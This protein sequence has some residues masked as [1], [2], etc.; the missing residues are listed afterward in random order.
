MGCQARWSRGCLRG[1]DTKQ[2]GEAAFLGRCSQSHVST[3]PREEVSDRRGPQCPL[4]FVICEEEGR[5]KAIAFNW[6]TSLVLVSRAL[7]SVLGSVTTYQVP[8]SCSV[9]VVFKVWSRD[10]WSRRS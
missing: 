2:L 6:D 9:T 3:Q 7:A 5:P 8:M 4:F 1:Q 10:P